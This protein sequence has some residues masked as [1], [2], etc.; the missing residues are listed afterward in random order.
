VVRR[1][2]A[3]LHKGHTAGGLYGK[4]RFRGVEVLR[5]GIAQHASTK[6]NYPATFVADGEHHPFAEAV[7][8]ASLIVGDQHARIDQRFTIFALPPK[9]LTRCPSRGRKTN[10]KTVITSLLIRAFPDTGA[11]AQRQ[12]ASKTVDKKCSGHPSIDKALPLMAL[13]LTGA[14]ACFIRHFKVVHCGQFFDGF[15][16]LELV[17][18]HE[19]VDGVAVRATA[20]AVVKLFFTVYGERGFFRYGTDS[21][22]DSSCPAFSAL[23]ARR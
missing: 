11:Q 5:Q 10:S 16:E 23:P 2:P 13:Y 4:Y 20:K 22:R 3:A 6:T 18:V 15:N 9:R 8:T 12:V 7:V 14:T 19:K 17:V 21:T 1:Y